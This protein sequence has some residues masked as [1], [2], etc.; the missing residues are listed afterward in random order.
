MIWVCD[1]VN[2]FWQHSEV[3]ECASLAIAEDQDEDQHYKQQ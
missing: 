2:D 1:F 3:M